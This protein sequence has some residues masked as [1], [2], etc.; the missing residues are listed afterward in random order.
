MLFSSPRSR[1]SQA[2][3]EIILLWTTSF[4]ARITMQKL[5]RDALEN[6]GLI[7]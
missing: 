2:A 1:S 5:L 4:H 6:R 3:L 7:G